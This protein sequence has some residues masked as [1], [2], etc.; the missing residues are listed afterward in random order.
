MILDGKVLAAEIKKQWKQEKYPQAEILP[1]YKSGKLYPDAQYFVLRAEGKI[2]AIANV[3]IQNDGW[4]WGEGT[5]YYADGRVVEG[6]FHGT[7]LIEASS[8]TQEP[9][10]PID[11]LSLFMDNQ[12][13][14]S[15]LELLDR[16][17]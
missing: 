5:M 13:L 15:G 12:S 10:S 2:Q 6:I 4:I 14:V 11:P 3:E 1:P 16:A 17:K 7:E 8:E 9:I